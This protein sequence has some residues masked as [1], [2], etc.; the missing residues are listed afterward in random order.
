MT[1]SVSRHHQA[2][3]NVAGTNAATAE[4]QWL[5]GQVTD[6]LCAYGPDHEEL[7][8]LAWISMLMLGDLTLSD[9]VV[10]T[11]GYPG[12]L[13]GVRLDSYDS[14]VDP[15]LV[16]V[17]A[18]IWEQLRGHLGDSLLRRLNGSY[19]RQST[20][21]E[22]RRPVMAALA[23]VASRYPAIE[24]MVRTEAGSDAELRRD[25]LSMSALKASPG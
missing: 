2:R 10:E 6:N 21:E 15:I 25:R 23:T 17:V 18:A 13:P 1:Q 22:Q 12:Q 14:D 24:E 5:R 8:Q 9:G 20:P 11:I 7:R 3:Q 4:M 19:H 16:D